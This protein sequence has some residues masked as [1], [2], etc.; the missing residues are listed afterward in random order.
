MIVETNVVNKIKD[1][2]GIDCFRRK[3][4]CLIILQ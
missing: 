4:I 2:V 1:S 3:S